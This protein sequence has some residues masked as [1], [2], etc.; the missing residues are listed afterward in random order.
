MII[1][2]TEIKDVYIIKN[3][4]R[5]RF[6]AEIYDHV[7]Y[8]M[9][10]YFMSSSQNAYHAIDD[11]RVEPYFSKLIHGFNE[12]KG[13][14]DTT[15]DFDWAKIAYPLVVAA[16]TDEWFRPIQRIKINL[17]P[18]TEELVHHAIHIDYPINQ[19]SSH[20][21]NQ[22]IN[23]MNIVYM[24]NTCDGYTEIFETD[25]RENVHEPQWTSDKDIPESITK[26][27]KVPSVENTAVIFP[28]HYAHRATST[29]NSQGRFTVN[30]NI[31]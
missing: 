12:T 3:F 4:I 2:E 24:I 16:S 5:K 30:C 11:P 23:I 19:K 31:L 18:K 25:P 10:W 26:S 21:W 20:P 7:C 27:I 1:Q 6:H 13:T 22:D 28:N 8:N 14:I 15:C 17:Y 9:D 29:T